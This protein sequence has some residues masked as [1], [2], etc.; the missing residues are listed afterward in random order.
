VRLGLD[1]IAFLLLQGGWASWL[2]GSWF[3]WGSG[4]WKVQSPRQ[5]L[6]LILL[7]TYTPGSE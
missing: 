5:R 7:H 1:R 3:P 4:G 2:G 6:I